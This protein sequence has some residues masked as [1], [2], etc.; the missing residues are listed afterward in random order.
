[1][2]FFTNTILSLIVTNT[3]EYAELQKVKSK[4]RYRRKWEPLTL[5]ELK[6]FLAISIYLGVHH[7]RGVAGLWK[8][9]EIKNY[10]PLQFITK[11]RYEQIRRFLH[12]SPASTDT[13]DNLW[14]MKLSA[15]FEH[16]R[17]AFKQYIVPPQNVAIDEMMVGFSGRSGHTLRAKHKPIKEG[18]KLWA[19]C[20]AGYTYDFLWYSRTKSKVSILTYC[21]LL[22]ACLE[23][24]ELRLKN[25]LSATGSM[26]YQLAK[27]LPYDRYTFSIYMDNYFSS[28]ELYTKLLKLGIGAAGTCRQNF[29]RAVFGALV[30]KKGG[31]NSDDNEEQELAENTS[32]IWGALHAKRVPDFPQ[33]LAFVWQDNAL[34][35]MLS[36][37]YSGNEWQPKE[38]RCPRVQTTAINRI[39]R[40]PF[41]TTDPETSIRETTW[42]QNL[43]IP[44]LINDYNQY[45]NGV[46]IADQYRR[47]L[48][49]QQTSRRN[50]HPL[51]YWLLDVTLV[52]IYL[53][54]K[55]WAATEPD[56]P[57]RPLSHKAF[58]L[59]IVDSLLESS[60]PRTSLAIYV[61]KD[62]LIA[63]AR[64][65]LP[66]HWHTEI[67]RG[68]RACYYCRLMR[69]KAIL[70]GK[71]PPSAASVR[72]SR[73][74]CAQCEVPLCKPPHTCWAD[75][76]AM[77]VIEDTEE[78]ARL[79]DLIN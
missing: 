16:L 3:N 32:Q 2:L 43:P 53:L 7:I 5:E 44:K 42:R 15:L 19:L 14:Y 56:P 6:V 57:I 27:A 74:H 70:D 50:W 49:S 58:R 36:T 67:H 9:S 13:A 37:I 76:H 47:N 29:T 73:V 62:D 64:R 26:V 59:A 39:A 41:T 34:V 22:I 40:A 24:A 10:P 28:P 46:D 18:F 23:T 52:N 66:S 48:K 65:Q 20:F 78:H 17:A 12:I 63:H 61:E 25:G 1:M 8:A 51:F 60:R 79:T 21:T 71:I 4:G 77:D 75:F 45:M 11:T 38:R 33:V 72:R 69:E 54:F 35:S 68:R 30:P 55:W 31:G